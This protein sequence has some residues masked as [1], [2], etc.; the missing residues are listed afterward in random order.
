MK[1]KR[2]F[3][4]Q[5]AAP[6]IFVLPFILSF[7]VFWIYPLFSTVKMSFQS[8][9][10][11]QIEWVGLANYEK[12]LKDTT[13]HTA[14]RNSLTYMFF[15]IALLI[16]FPML[17]AV[18][19]DSSLVK[20]KGFWK[21]A[22]YLPALTSVVISG[23][24]F[25]LMFSELPTGQM[26]VFLNFL[27]KAPIPW[28]K[29]RS[30]A[31]CALLTLCCWRWT[32][33]NM[34]YFLSGLKSIDTTLYESAAIDGA[35]AWNK[36]RYITIPLLRPTTIYVLTISVYAGLSMFLESFMLWAGNAS[37]KN[38]GLTIVGYLY[39][40][41]IEKNQMG[42]ASAVGLTLLG[43]ALIINVVQLILNG[44]FRKEEK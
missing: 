41:G 10:P 32:G 38:I 30:F 15:S 13:F 44:T 33:V 35:S 21:G 23:T 36:F 19:M 43:M 5:K 26:N 25:R 40:R 29:E 7:T 9:L 6:F 22:L 11:G 17:F 20:A 4:S 16:P 39:K 12:L 31:M 37:P 1:I 27:G 28:L 34:L 3:Y 8:I 24:L 18:L 14:I 2:I 42:Y